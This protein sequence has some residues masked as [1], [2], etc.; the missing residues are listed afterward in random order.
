MRVQPSAKDGF[1]LVRGHRMFRHSV[2]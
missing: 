1:L 2:K